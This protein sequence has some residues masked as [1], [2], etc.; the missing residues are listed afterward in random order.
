MVHHSDRLRISS[1][2][3][4]RSRIPGEISDD[5]TPSGGTLEYGNYWTEAATAAALV[6]HDLH[7]T[8]RDD[9]FSNDLLDYSKAWA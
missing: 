8:A 7:A 2:E 1:R 4:L 6:A 5:S 3:I 9:R